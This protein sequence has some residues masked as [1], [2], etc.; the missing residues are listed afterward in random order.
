MSTVPFVATTTPAIDRA[1]RLLSVTQNPGFLD[2]MRISQEIVKEAS[3]ILIQFGGWDE[4]QISI[5]KAR[6]Q[7]ATEHHS[8]LFARIQDAIR[9]GIADDAARNQIKPDARSVEDVIEQGDL[10]RQKV[11]QKFDVLDTETRV[12]GSF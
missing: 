10:V 5:L 8:A 1:N 9:Q 2:I 12:A 7:A 4:K 3:D 6:A 11:L